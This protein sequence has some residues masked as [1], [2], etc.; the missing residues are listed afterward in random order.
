MEF[1]VFISE[2]MP[3][4]WYPDSEQRAFDM[5][6]EL[7]VLADELGFGYLWISEHHFLE[8]YCHSSSPELMLAAL[9]R[10]TKQIRL[11][12]GIVDLQPKMN[13]PIR[14]AER[15]ATLD[16]LSHGR[17]EFGT[18]RGSGATEWGGFE[19]AEPETKANWEEALRAIL[20]MWRTDRFSWDGRAFKI[21]ERNVIP[22]PV[23]KPHPPLWMACTNPGTQREAGE[24]GVGS[25]CFIYAGLDD[26]I[27]RLNLY[28]EGQANPKGRF[29]EVLNNRFAYVTG[30]LVNQDDRKAREIFTTR[31]N[32]YGALF[33]RYWPKSVGGTMQVTDRPRPP[34]DFDDIT[35]R[36]GT[37]VGDPQRALDT[38]KAYE[39][40]GFDQVIF[41]F[42]P[43]IE[44]LDSVKN[45]LRLLAEYV[46]PEFQKDAIPV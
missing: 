2:A 16:L 27:E 20:A 43:M 42:H 26:V 13:H 39:E 22:K 37:V 34:I 15:I 45:T 38:L 41:G 31:A 21:P 25:L 33:A 17:V 18:G 14:V 10:A 30:A 36:R 5:D 7:G 24:R 46:L 1:G 11:S 6:F 19:T 35:N 3:K 8:E 4:P 28:R 44:G 23:Q 40:I 9:S 29:S 12:H 32:P